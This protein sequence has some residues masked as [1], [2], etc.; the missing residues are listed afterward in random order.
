M[1]SDRTG[2]AERPA[3]VSAKVDA[4]PRNS[5]KL[6]YKEQRELEGLPAKM[7]ALEQE[8]LALRQALADADIYVRDPMG[9]AQMHGR[10]AAIEEELMQ[11]LQRWEDLSS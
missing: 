10:D 9:A 4:P 6:S 5:K 3:P 8:Q 2:Q 11:C 7:Q 1:T